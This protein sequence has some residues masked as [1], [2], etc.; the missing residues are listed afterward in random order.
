MARNGGGMANRANNFPATLTIT[1]ST[2]SGNSANVFGGGVVNSDNNA[3]ATLTLNN[4]TI[5]G[6]SANDG[7][8]GA[9]NFTNNTAATLTI[10]NST[11][12]GNTAPNGQEIRKSG[13][14]QAVF[15]ANN[16]NLFGHSGL[17]NAQAFVN[18]TPSTP[19]DITATSDGSMPTALA[20]ILDTTLQDNGGETA[21]HN[22]VSGS[23]AIDA[24]PSG[25]STDQRGVTRPVGSA[26]DIGA[27]EFDNEAPVISAVTLISPTGTIDTPR[28]TFI[29][30]PASDSGGVIG[31]TLLLTDSNG[32]TTTV[33]TTGPSYTPAAD[34]AT[35]DYT[36]T[37]KAHDTAGNASDYVSPAASFTLTSD[38]PSVSTTIYLPMILK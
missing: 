20:D 17:T 3:A 32:L 7:G 34:L 19:T 6:N 23:P 8:G 26:F 18:F 36:W 4:S 13:D 27:V 35:G 25:S 22:P 28:P 14:P 21:T 24:A 9:A 12:S 15:I 29:W 31:Y 1:N 38:S 33:T 11:I 5:S 2:V 10:N 16:Y 30:N 37:V